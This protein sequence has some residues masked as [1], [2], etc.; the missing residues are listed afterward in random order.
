[1]STAQIKFDSRPRA[2]RRREMLRLKKQKKQLERKLKRVLMDIE[3]END[4]ITGFGNF[5]LL[6]TFKKSIDLNGIIRE[7]FTTPLS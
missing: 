6:E 4:N 2:E 7:L 1:M 5:H 3:F